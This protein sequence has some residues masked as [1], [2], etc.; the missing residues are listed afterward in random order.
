M[1]SSINAL[2]SRRRI[3]RNFGSIAEVA[4]MP[5]LI[6]VQRSS[7]DLFLQRDVPPHARDDVGLQ[8]VFKSVFPIKDFNEKSVLEYVSYTLEEPKYDV[9]EC[10]QRGLNYASSLKVLLRLVVWE[11]DEI[12]GTKSLRDTKEQEVFMGDMP[13]MTKNG[14]FII[15]GTEP[16]TGR[17]F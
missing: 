8:E 11:E 1:G 3:R 7:Y 17:I 13:L 5:N 16:V 4:E 12:T 9:E 10:Q 15:N 2:N 6:D 14:T